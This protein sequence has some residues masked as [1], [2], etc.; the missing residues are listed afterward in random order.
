LELD[1]KPKQDLVWDPFTGDQ[2]RFALPL[3]FHSEKNLTTNG[4]V[5]HAAGDGRHFHVVL[6]VTH[7]NDPLHTQALVCVYSSESGKWGDLISTPLTSGVWVSMIMPALLNANFLY[8]QL[9]GASF[10]VLEFDLER[11]RLAVVLMPT[12][13]YAMA[14]CG[15]AVTTQAEGGGPCFLIV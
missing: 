2:H 15:F 5:L 11:Q 10:G 7:G 13:L 9:N 14:I 4:A 12:D 3:G 1:Q 8:W 6:V